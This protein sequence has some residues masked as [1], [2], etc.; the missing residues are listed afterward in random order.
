MIIKD[1]ITMLQSSVLKQIKVGEDTTAIIGYINMG[2]LEI[3]KRFR[4]SFGEATITPVPG[5]SVY[6]LDG[7]D[8]DVSIDLSSGELLVIETILDP[9]YK[10]VAINKVIDEKGTKTLSFNTVRLGEEETAASYK[11]VFRTSPEFSL[12]DTQAIPLSSV[13]LE[14]LFHYVG[15]LAYLSQTG[16]ENTQH[17]LYKKRFDESIQRIAASGLYSQNDMSTDKLYERGL[18]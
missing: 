15:Y 1:A 16:E 5:K 2:V 10:P 17:N 6:K 12:V 11:V 3:H 13:F 8:T 14:S 18:V 7:I 9:D 4:L